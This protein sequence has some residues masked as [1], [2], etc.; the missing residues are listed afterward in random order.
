MQRI[1]RTT[2][3][4]IKGSHPVA[5]HMNARLKD[6]YLKGFKNLID[7]C[8]LMVCCSLFRTSSSYRAADKKMVIECK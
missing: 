5:L 7:P 1:M 2:Y 6:Y 4:V 8:K 3:E